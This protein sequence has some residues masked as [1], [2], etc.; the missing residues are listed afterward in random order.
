MHRILIVG[1]GS[2]GERHLR[3]FLK[4][5]RAEVALCDNRPERLKQIAAAYPLVGAYGDFRQVELSQF[6]A[7]AICVPAD[8]HVPWARKA[9]EA[10]AHVL[11]EKPLALSLDGIDDLDRLAKRK[12][13][14]VG[15]AHV[16]RA[17][18]DM[19]AVKRELDSG[20]I[21]DVLACSCI[22]GYDHRT[23][24]PDYRNTYW[25]HREQGGG[26]I[27][28]V[29]SHVTNMIQWYMGPVKSVMADYEHLQIEGTQAEDTLAYLLRFRNS[30]AIGSVHIVAWQAHRTDQ[31]L[32]SGT[33]GSIV[34]DSW[35]GRVGV[36]LRDGRWV[37]TEGL[38]DKPDAKGQTDGPF[39]HEDSNF[40]D[41]TE[42]KGEIMC[43]LLEA[44]HTI[45]V[46]LA[47][48][49]SGRRHAEVMLEERESMSG[50]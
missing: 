12:G 9:V 35:E 17:M 33:K 25:A 3:C 10:G 50:R 13:R 38:K 32:L 31:L 27:F 2:I 22:I 41:A 5:G 43:S 24:R 49:E 46:C 39:V 16:R 30:P 21:G 29:S 23:A 47:T 15:V 20:K 34:C 14:V 36:V 1:G 26:A 18:P 19:R 48:D 42:G 37:W 6:H 44:R 45:E 28:D 4:T 11:I 8:L 7:V 40:L